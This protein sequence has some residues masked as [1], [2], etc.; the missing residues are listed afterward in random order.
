VNLGGGPR[1]QPKTAKGVPVYLHDWYGSGRTAM[2][3]S[4]RSPEYKA[5]PGEFH[6]DAPL[7]GDESRVREVKDVDFPTLL[8]PVDDLPPITVITHVAKQEDKLLVRGSASDNGEIKRV[9]VNGQEAHLNLASGEW[10]V[11]L[12]GNTLALTAYS[13]DALGNTEKLSHK[14]QIQSEN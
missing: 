10:R 6:E 9:I 2:V 12:P 7:T 13:E 4:T 1:P 8:N 14:F 11:E 3:V 5:S